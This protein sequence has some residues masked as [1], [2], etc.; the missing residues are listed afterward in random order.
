MKTG[1]ERREAIINQIRTSAVP[2]SGGLLARTFEVSRQVIVQDIALIRAAGY[3]I[4]STNRGYILN[5]SHL[6]YR[7]FKVHHTDEEL[8]NEL[9]AIVDLGGCVV[10]VMVN[11]RIYGHLE[12]ELQI[13]SRRKVMEFVEDM[14]SGKSK[15]L[16]N[17]TSNYHYHRVEADSEETLDMIEEMLYKKGYLVCEN[18][19]D[20]STDQSL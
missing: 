1:S 3:D 6:A 11:H 16:K 19:N 5:T 9:C 2:I 12:A 15:P 14:K 8:E 18:A 10:N 7:V 13:N 20:A 4:I 17:I